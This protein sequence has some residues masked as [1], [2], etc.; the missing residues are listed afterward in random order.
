M[1]GSFGMMEIVLI[2][3]VGVVVF[4]V[5]KLPGLARSIGS[6]FREFK[7]LKR[8]FDLGLDGGDEEPQDRRTKQ[9]TAYGHY[10][11]QMDQSYYQ[12]QQPGP[13]GQFGASGGPR[14]SPDQSRPADGGGNKSN[15]NNEKNA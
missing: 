13:Q 8:G 5:I 3:I 2:L 14:F 11:Q 10:T 1:F 9:D 12:N 6:G 15:P 7:N 4:G